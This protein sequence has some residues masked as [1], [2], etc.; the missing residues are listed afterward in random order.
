MIWY[1]AELKAKISGKTFED[2]IVRLDEA[3]KGIN[4]S[5]NQRIVYF[6]DTEKLAVYHSGTVLIRFRW[7]NEIL[8]SVIKIRHSPKHDLI[9][10]K[11]E[12][13]GIEGHAIKLDGDGLTDKEIQWS[14]SLKYRFPNINPAF[15][16]FGSPADYITAPQKKLLKKLAPH[17]N[18][19]DL[20]FGIPIE[21]RA[22]TFD[23]EF[24]E[25]SSITLEQWRL[26][27]LL[28]DKSQEVSIKT[29][30][31]SDKSQKHFL[32]LLEELQ[33]DIS[34]DSALKSEWYYHSYFN[35]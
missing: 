26:P 21:S 25:F 33:I 11:K 31:Y 29:E 30:T 22:Y 32:E 23:T 13:E 19:A 2:A 28:G 7:N 12:Y 4:Y 8:E 35:I 9:A 34:L 16:F 1:A 18:V 3:V 24:K 17:V 15:A 6:A 5:L 14:M 27:R 10:I 20:K